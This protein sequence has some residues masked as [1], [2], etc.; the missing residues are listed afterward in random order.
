MH[1]GLLQNVVKQKIPQLCHYDGYDLAAYHH[2]YPL[3]PKDIE[4]HLPPTI[5]TTMK[6]AD[7]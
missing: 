3:N 7:F 4:A 6:E 2:V 5:M 1:S